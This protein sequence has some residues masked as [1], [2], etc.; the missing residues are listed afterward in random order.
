MSQLDK[1]SAAQAL[2]E[3]ATDSSEDSTYRF[4]AAD[5]LGQLDENLATEALFEIAT[6]SFADISDRVEAADR[7]GQLNEALA[8]Q[9]LENIA[10]KNQMLQLPWRHSRWLIIL[11]AGSF[12]IL[13]GVMVLLI[14]SAAR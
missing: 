14:C 1:G 6:D 9:A 11:G 12:V 13:V 5:R 7:L 10:E 2:S 3:I 8:A 4:E